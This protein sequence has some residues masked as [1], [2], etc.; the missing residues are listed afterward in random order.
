MPLKSPKSRL[1]LWLYRL[2][3][4]DGT[5]R[6]LSGCCS[7][8]SKETCIMRHKLVVTALGFTLTL[9]LV[10]AAPA[11]LL[12]T[13][14]HN[15][16][17]GNN[18]L[19]PAFWEDLTAETDDLTLTGQTRSA[20]ASAPGGFAYTFDGSGSATVPN[21]ASWVNTA[22]FDVSFEVWFKPANLVDEGDLGE[23]IVETGGNKGLA[24]V[25]DGDQ[26]RFTHGN[27]DGDHLIETTITAGSFI[28][29]VG[30][31]NNTGGNVSSLYV[32]GLPV[33]TPDT[34]EDWKGTGNAAG[35]G[36][37]NGGD[38]TGS[39][40]NTGIGMFSHFS[41]D[42]AIMRMYDGALT[43]AEVLNNYN[44]VVIPEPSSLLLAAL[45]LLG[46]LC[47]RRRRR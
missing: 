19:D 25:L 27:A 33:G 36:G 34:T 7:S 32:N 26:L 24:I 20:D 28:Q 4:L 10:S 9:L 1:S 18:P 15:Y 13:L 40:G 2:G 45:G 41:G 23:V 22:N 42:I 31:V 47:G 38:Q 35:V 12:G 8:F 30:V 14:H 6:R 46:L 43:D 5:G 11:A 29:V 17:A 3:R 37:I 44:E 39:Y 16:E 21:T